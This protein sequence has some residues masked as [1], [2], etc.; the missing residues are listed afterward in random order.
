MKY[1]KYNNNFEEQVLAVI[2]I[3]IILGMGTL[4][5]CIKSQRA[6]GWQCTAFT[7]HHQHFLKHTECSERFSRVR[8]HNSVLSDLG[9]TFFRTTVPA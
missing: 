4:S 6:N 8:T 2:Y 5:H 7:D 1:L 9:P 3:T